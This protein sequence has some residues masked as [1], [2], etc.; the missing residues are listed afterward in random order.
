MARRPDC[1][2]LAQAK[3]FFAAAA[4]APKV[5]YGPGRGKLKGNC[6]SDRYA[7]VQVIQ[8]KTAGVN[9]PPAK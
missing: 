5:P 3:K 4:A 1:F 8:V 7:Y 9:R 6:N 2:P